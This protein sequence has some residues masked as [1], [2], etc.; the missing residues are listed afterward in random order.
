MFGVWRLLF[1]AA[2]NAGFDLELNSTAAL[3]RCLFSKWWPPARSPALLLSLTL[4]FCSQ[5]WNVFHLFGF[6]SSAFL[7]GHFFSLIHIIIWFISRL[8][9]VIKRI[10]LVLCYSLSC[11]TVC[12][13]VTSLTCWI[14]E[15][16]NYV[17]YQAWHIVTDNKVFI[18]H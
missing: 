12:R 4:L 3:P 17:T 16:Q 13:I 6:Y 18:E 9:G 14:S 11:C 5:L 8:N 15:V 2:L 10:V 7:L 1:H